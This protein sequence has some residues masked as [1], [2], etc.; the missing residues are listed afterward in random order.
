MGFLLRRGALRGAD[1]W[2]TLP[3]V[4]GHTSKDT[5]YVCPYWF[6]LHPFLAHYQEKNKGGSCDPRGRTGVWHAATGASRGYERWVVDLKRYAGKEVEVSLSYASDDLFEYDGVYIDD[7]VVTGAPGTTSFED[8]ADPLDGWTVAGAPVGTAPNTDDWHTGTS[9]DVPPSVGEIAASDLDRQPEILRFLSGL[10]GPYPWTAS[11]SIVDDIKGLGFALENQTRV[12]Y[13]PDFFE[14]RASPTD[15]VV[16]HELAHQWVGDSL[17]VAAWQDIW[18]NEG[19]ATYT[20]WLWDEHESRATADETFASFA[21]IPPHDPFWSLPIGDPGPKHLFDYPVYARGAMTLHALR[22]KIGDTAF[23]DLLHEWVDRHADGNVTTP[24]FIALAE[25]VS[26]QPLDGFF[27]RWLFTAERPR[28][29]GSIGG[30]RR[31]VSVSGL[32]TYR[33]ELRATGT[34]C[35]LDAISRNAEG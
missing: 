9:A 31:Q 3:D 28:G 11:G 19:F 17:S 33:M 14:D 21:G 24:E 1:D 32:S 29:L 8:D 4:N 18:L 34:G 10:F 25:E 26:G 7:V 12:I 27:H 16:V 30:V 2:T 23:F 6:E 15:D 35:R 22:T 5:G 20:E 13:S